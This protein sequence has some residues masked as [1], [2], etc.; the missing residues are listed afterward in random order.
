MITFR[1]LTLQELN[2]HIL[3]ID[4]SEHGEL[5]YSWINGEVTPTPVVWNRPRWRTEADWRDSTWLVVE[6]LPGVKAWGAFD[7]DSMVGVIVYRPHLTADTA[8]LAALFVSCSH[9]RMGVAARLFA[10]LRQQAAADGHAKLYV[11]ATES[12]SAVGFY[13]SQG[14]IPT[15]DVNAELFALEPRDIHMIMDL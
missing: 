3:D 5:I 9:R 11:S 2:E 13:R 6:K 8:Q 12:A 7:G 1:E 15:Q 14:F 10:L 4:V